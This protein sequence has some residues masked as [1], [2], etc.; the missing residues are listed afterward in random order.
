MFKSKLVRLSVASTSLTYLPS[1]N[2]WYAEFVRKTKSKLI[3]LTITECAVVGI[4]IEVAVL[5]A[6]SDILLLDEAP[7]LI[8]LLYTRLQN[9][10]QIH[11][12]ITG[13]LISLNILEWNRFSI[14]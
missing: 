8:K 1:A 4:A 11:E 3:A 12:K 14:L 6:K 7:T 13:L 10:A 5:K 2:L 9:V